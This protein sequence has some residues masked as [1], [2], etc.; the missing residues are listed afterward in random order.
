M[1]PEQL[2]GHRAGPPADVYA[3]APCSSRPS[4]ESGHVRD[5]RRWRS[6]RTRTAGRRPTCASTSRRL[7]PQPPTSSGGRSTEIRRNART[8]P[9]SW[10][11]CSPPPLRGPTPRPAPSPRRGPSPSGRA[12]AR[13]R[14][15]DR[16]RRPATRAAGSRCPR[17]SRR[18]RWWRRG[19]EWSRSP[20]RATTAAMAARTDVR[21]P[22][23]GPRPRRRRK[24]SPRRKRP[25][26]WPRRP[27]LRSP[28][29][30]RPG[31]AAP[32]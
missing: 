2:D 30:P 22:P 4:P 13:N 20:P 9:E 11:R 5:A 16:R 12:R 23:R 15:H 28:P 32:S 17:R 10:P 29:D 14:Y 7:R 26:S 21:P 8:A 18:W 27:R 19:W 31:R 25:R 3:S 6:C 24:R 1:A